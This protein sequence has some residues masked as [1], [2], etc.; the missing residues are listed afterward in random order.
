[1]N[2]WI[3]APP[4]KPVIMNI[5]FEKFWDKFI[6]VSCLSGLVFLIAISVFR[7]FYLVPAQEQAARNYG[8]IQQLQN[9]NRALKTE[10]NR[11]QKKLRDE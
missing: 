3:P 9:E 10:I 6:L 4:D 11:L 7:Y 8:H 1:M 2:F 5:K